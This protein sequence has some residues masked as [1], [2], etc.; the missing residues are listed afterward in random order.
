MCMEV[1]EDVFVAVHLEILAAQFDGDDFFVAELRGKATAAQAVR[2]TGTDRC[3]VFTDQA[4]D[5]NDKIISIH[6]GA[7][8][9]LVDVVINYSYILTEAPRWINHQ[10]CRTLGDIYSVS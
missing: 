5:G 7:S 3:V 4:V 8:R 10:K 1:V 6:S 9:R 2:Q